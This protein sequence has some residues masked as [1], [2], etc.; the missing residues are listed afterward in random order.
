MID[1]TES[2]DFTKPIRFRSDLFRRTGIIDFDV[3]NERNKLLGPMLEGSKEERNLLKA[4]LDYLSQNTHSCERC[5]K[6]YIVKP[7][8]HYAIDLCE[9]CSRA[10]ENQLLEVNRDVI[11]PYSIPTAA[12]ETDQLLQLWSACL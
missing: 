10:I 1:L 2:R 7:W 12:D 3:Y 9:D 5:G 11:K 4:E 8:A 6:A